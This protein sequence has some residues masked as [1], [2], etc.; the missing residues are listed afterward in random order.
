LTL[1]D[2]EGIDVARGIVVGR[3][4]KSSNGA[5]DL[6]AGRVTDTRIVAPTPAGPVT[7]APFEFSPNNLR[8]VKARCRQPACVYD[9]PQLPRTYVTVR[10]ARNSYVLGSMK[11]GDRLY[12]GT[13]RKSSRSQE[14]WGG[15]VQS[16]GEPRTYTGCG[17]VQVGNKNRQLRLVRSNGGSLR[18]CSATTRGRPRDW[19]GIVERAPF[20]PSKDPCVVAYRHAGRRE[21][22]QCEVRVAKLKRLPPRTRPKDPEQEEENKADGRRRDPPTDRFEEQRRELEAVRARLAT[23]VTKQ[24]TPVYRNAFPNGFGRPEGTSI[25]PLEAL[26]GDPNLPIGTRVRW[27]YLT[28]KNPSTKKRYVLALLTGRKFQGSDSPYGNRFQ[29]G[30]GWVFIDADAF[31]GPGQ[32]IEQAVCGA[33]PDRRVRS[34]ERRT[35]MPDAVCHRHALDWTK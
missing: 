1:R 33:M 24:P 28:K 12:T 8:A 15:Y 26:P 22:A 35:Q 29:S 16:R 5:P 17:Y 4:D 30:L 20:A 19:M 21:R 6:P 14:W 11:A 2:P 3:T 25:D 18:G 31:R 10:R 7:E 27:R 23:I 13:H 32:T 34:S 9:F